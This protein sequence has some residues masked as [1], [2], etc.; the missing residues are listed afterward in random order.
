MS[1]HSTET[2]PMRR[3]AGE[4]LRAFRQSLGMTQQ[5]LADEIGVTQGMVNTFEHGKRG[6]TPRIAA[7]LN[8]RFP[9][10]T[11][12]MLYL[13]DNPETQASDTSPDGDRAHLNGDGGQP[14]NEPSSFSGRLRFARSSRG[15]TQLQLGDAVGRNFT[16][17]SGWESG[18][19]EPSDYLIRHLAHV[20][21]VDPNWL[22]GKDGLEPYDPNPLSSGREAIDARDGGFEL[23]IAT[24]IS[25]HSKARILVDG[26]FGASEI[27]GLIKVLTLHREFMAE[28]GSD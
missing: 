5:Q 4:K 24:P 27:D 1:D 20:L 16:T 28:Q 6:I 2:E 8:Q 18:K 22:A 15:L 9:E 23:H 17:V 11:P 26:P 10:I 19:S 21:D 3:A 13:D 12:N 25:A 14:R 7:R